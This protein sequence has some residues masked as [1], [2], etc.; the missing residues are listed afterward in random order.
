[1]SPGAPPPLVLFPRPTLQNDGAC[2]SLRFCGSRA[3]KETTVI[4]GMAC[5]NALHFARLYLRMQ[6]T[7]RKCKGW[8]R[9]IC[10]QSICL[11][12]KSVA[13]SLYDIKECCHWKTVLAYMLRDT[14]YKWC[15]CYDSAID[16]VAELV[17]SNMQGVLV[18][19]LQ[20]QHAS[21]THTPHTHAILTRAQTLTKHCPC[22]TC[23][24]LL[25]P[26]PTSAQDGLDLCNLRWWWCLSCH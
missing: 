21:H 14:W 18:K 1:M 24:W 23:N 19:V 16:R 12:M 4:S 8:C 5:S 11:Y 9:Q 25:H 26:A 13:I 7:W 2:G 15:S 20:I 17:L 22:A 10:S 6:S 3:G